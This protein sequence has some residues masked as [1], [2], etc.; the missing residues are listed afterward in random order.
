M[1]KSE[2]NP[3]K[4]DCVM[5][6]LVTKD[7]LYLS[8]QAGEH[9]AKRVKYMYKFKLN[10]KTFLKNVSIEPSKV[11]TKFQVSSTSIS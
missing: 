1:S 7:F 2:L 11:C 3:T 6:L 4:N 9:R 8:L 10:P 5:R